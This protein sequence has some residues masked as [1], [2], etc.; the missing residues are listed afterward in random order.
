MHT[1]NRM[2]TRRRHDVSIDAESD[3]IRARRLRAQVLA[4]FF[5]AVR[6]RVL[7]A[8]RKPSGTNGKPGV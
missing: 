2:D 5:R 3:V 4:G 8:L 6:H 1:D 7:T